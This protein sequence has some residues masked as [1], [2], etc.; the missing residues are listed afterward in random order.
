[1]KKKYLL[2]LALCLFPAM[3]SATEV[4]VTWE[5]MLDD[6]DVTG[7]R[8][9]LD[10]EDPDGWTTVLPDTTSYTA[11]NLDG[12]KAY[13]LYLQQTYDGESWSE[14][15]SETSTVFDQTPAVETAPA[16]A[17][18]V[19]SSDNMLSETPEEAPL[20]EEVTEP[21]MMSEETETPV[22]SETAPAQD[23]TVV[24]D[25]DEKMM[26]TKDTAMM[27]SDAPFYASVDISMGADYA[28]DD[29]FAS[30]KD[31]YE[32]YIPYVEVSVGLNNIVSYGNWGM[33]VDFSADAMA[34]ILQDSST[35]ASDAQFDYMDNTVRVSFTPM[36]QYRAGKAEFE[37]GP[38]VNLNITKSDD[39]SSYIASL[40]ETDYSDDTIALGYGLHLGMGYRMTD[41]FY[42]TVK[43]NGLHAS[44]GLD[45]T[46]GWSVGGSVGL[47]YS[48]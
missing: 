34:Y 36:L 29:T 25:T 41:D 11:Q 39:T 40:I 48:F 35:A 12:G 28:L 6:P 47:G 33:G 8:Y 43:A 38:T 31:Y 22:L 45:L 18:P 27:S 42:L 7:F 20:A 13:T 26:M 4:A 24:I 3:L 10:S 16:P 44:Q 19:V 23:D 37:I 9:Q 21:A 1:M 14:S 32:S 15:A 2:L 46:D 30:T 17:A 5:W